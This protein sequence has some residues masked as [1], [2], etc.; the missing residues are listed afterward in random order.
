[1]QLHNLFKNKLLFSMQMK[2]QLKMAWKRL[3]KVRK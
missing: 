3:K 1:M 2:K